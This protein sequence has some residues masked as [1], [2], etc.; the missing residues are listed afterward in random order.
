MFHSDTAAI[1]NQHL[2]DGEAGALRQE[3]VPPQPSEILLLN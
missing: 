2:D 1:R 3:P